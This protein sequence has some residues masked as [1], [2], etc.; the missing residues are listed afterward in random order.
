MLLLRSKDGKARV[1]NTSSSM[2]YYAGTID[3]GL[4]RN[5]DGGDK[6]RKKKGEMGLYT[7]SKFV[8][9]SS[10]YIL[11]KITMEDREMS[12]S[13]TSWLA[14]MVIKESY[15]PPSTRGISRRAYKEI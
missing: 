9:R 1:V 11:R 15:L 6:L 10:S 4:L 3:F 13:R 14:D 7:Q 12:C 2:A 8:R 5:D